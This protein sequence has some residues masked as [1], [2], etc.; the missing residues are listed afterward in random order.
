MK[1]DLNDVDV[2]ATID[3]NKLEISDDKEAGQIK[4]HVISIIWIGDHYQVIVR[5]EK[6]KT[7]FLESP[8]LWNENDFVSVKVESE[9]ISLKLKAELVAL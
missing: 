3:F 9:D 5:T 8:Y 7:L 4:G 2:I 1:Y 6:K